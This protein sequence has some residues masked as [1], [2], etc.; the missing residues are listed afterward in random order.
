VPVA[1]PDLL[2]HRHHLAHVAAAVHQVHAGNELRSGID[3]P[4]RHYVESTQG[5]LSLRF[6]PGHAPELNPD[7]LVAYMRD[8]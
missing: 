5:K 2:V 6:L 3:R 8:C 1:L 7:E 4:L